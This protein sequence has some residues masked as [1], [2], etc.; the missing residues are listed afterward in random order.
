MQVRLEDTTEPCCFRLLD[1]AQVGRTIT[2]TPATQRLAHIG[3][4]EPLGHALALGLNRLNGLETLGRLQCSALWIV[5]HHQAPLTPQSLGDASS[6]VYG[7][8][9]LGKV[10]VASGR[11]RQNVLHQ[12][13]AK[14]LE[15]LHRLHIV[16]TQQP[17]IGHQ[18]HPLAVIGG[19]GLLDGRQQRG[20]FAHVAGVDLVGDGQA[21]GG[22][23]HAENELAR[24]AAGAL[25]QAEGAKNI[26]HC[27]FAVD[28]HGGQVVEDHEQGLIQ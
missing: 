25:V 9:Y 12:L 22:L 28:A 2:G 5:C 3:I 15:C 19:N 7:L 4:V 18:H 20:D 6:K 24:D 11:Y 14:R 8:N 1:K 16:Q 13:A 26:F 21:F 23:D 10:R 27:P 17:A